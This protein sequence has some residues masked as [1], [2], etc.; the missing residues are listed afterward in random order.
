MAWRRSRGGYYQYGDESP[1]GATSAVG[2]AAAVVQDIEVDL[3]ARPAERPL[4]IT[5]DN[6]VKVVEETPGLA[7][8]AVEHAGHVG[9][10]DELMSPGALLFLRDSR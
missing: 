4:Q 2:R 7:A 6:E 3:R 1:G 10:I 8:A 9:G 5:V